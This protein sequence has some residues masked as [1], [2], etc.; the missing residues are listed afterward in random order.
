MKGSKLLLVFIF[1]VTAA[2]GGTAIWIGWR[3]SQEEEVIPETGVAADCPGGSVDAC[4]AICKEGCSG[5]EYPEECRNGCRTACE[6]MCDDSADCPCGDCNETR[7]DT[8]Q[9]ETQRC[10]T[11]GWRHTGER[12]YE[13][14][15]AEDGDGDGDGDD[16]GSEGCGPTGSCPW[17]SSGK[18]SCC[19]PTATCTASRCYGGVEWAITGT[20]S[21]GQMMTCSASGPSCTSNLCGSCGGCPSGWHECNAGDAGAEVKEGSCSDCNNPYWD[22]C[23]P[24]SGDGDGDGDGDGGEETQVSGMVYCEEE[25]VQIPLPGVA[26]RIYHHPIGTFNMS[27]Y[28]TTASGTFSRTIDRSGAVRV[29]LQN[30]NLV[31]SSVTFGGTVYDT[32]DLQ[33][34]SAVNCINKCGDGS[35]GCGTSSYSGGQS[36]EHCTVSGSSMSGFNFRFTNCPE[37]GEDTL[38]CD[39]LTADGG[40]SVTVIPGQSASADLEVDIGGTLS[41]GAITYEYDADYGTAS[42]STE[43]GTWSITAAQSEALSVGT[44]DDA[45]WVTI[46]GGGLS[47]GGQGTACSVYLVVQQGE[48]DCESIVRSP[49]S[50]EIAAGSDVWVQIEDSCELSYS[51]VDWYWSEGESGTAQ[52][53]NFSDRVPGSGDGSALNHSAI[54]SVPSDASGT[55]CVWART[56]GVDDPDCRE[57]F[58]IGG[59]ESPAF[60]AVKTSEMVCINDN[61]AAQITYTINVRNISD[62]E[63]VIEYVEDTYDSRIQS[64]WVGSITPTPDSHGGN[65]IRWDNDDSGYTLSA[66]DG[67]SGGTDEVEFSYIVTVPAEYFG[68]TVNGVFDPYEYRNH[69]VVKPEDQDEIDLRTVVEIVCGVPTGVFDKAVT[70]V[71]L[72]LLFVMMG[73]VLLRTHKYTYKYIMPIEK[74]LQENIS[75]KLK[76]TKKERFEKKAVK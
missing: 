46:S 5:S 13:G 42:G 41:S 37:L 12:C 6:G 23:C 30:I 61:T 63:G 45:I 2:L 44:Y 50:T 21:A 55:I 47:R 33:S 39:D 25:G 10:Q 43:T 72:G 20:C 35:N 68:T 69:A 34:L 54:F 36:F 59:E 49:S 75:D 16:D 64:S 62:V 3:L 29:F 28:P 32:S 18:G 15:C 56:E 8:S 7:C 51:D 27:P 9:C 74:L 71:L 1:V 76:L 65:V 57:C 73:G 11:N 48:C 19:V 24:D 66:N 22:Y 58:T 14:S 70:S 26:V 4:T 53:T 38:T 40:G 60:A 52:T 31:P 67:S 17:L